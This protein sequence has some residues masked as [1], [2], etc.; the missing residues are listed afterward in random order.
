MSAFS[1]ITAW[2]IFSHETITPR[3]IT[4]K[5]QLKLIQ[6]YFEKFQKLSQIDVSVCNPVLSI[7]TVVSANLFPHRTRTESKP[8][9]EAKFLD[10]SSTEIKSKILF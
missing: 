8:N 3:S 6:V 10:N 2:I 7:S 1:F 9:F 4:L 5:V